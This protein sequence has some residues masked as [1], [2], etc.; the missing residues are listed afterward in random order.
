MKFKV[1]AYTEKELSF[2]NIYLSVYHI[3]SLCG[4]YRKDITSRQYHAN[5]KDG[6]VSFHNEAAVKRV[7]R[8]LSKIGVDVKLVANFP[9]IYLDT[10]NGV[11]VSGTKNSEHGWCITYHNTD[12]R[13]LTFRRDLF[14]KIRE[15]VGG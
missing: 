8:R 3:Q 4:K 10:V 5:L 15:I 11:K 9:W 6:L 12:L 14:S 7:C 2:S 13:N 1:I